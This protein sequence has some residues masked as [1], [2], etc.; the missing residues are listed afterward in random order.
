MSSAIES[1]PMLDEAQGDS[2]R[3]ALV[4][5]VGDEY[6][7]VRLIGRGGMGAVYL[8][9]DRALER[10]VAIKVLPPGSATDAGVLERFRREAKTV[11]SLQHVGIVPLYAFGERRGLV[12]FVMGYVRGES[13]GTRLDR[14]QVLD[15][16][17]AR[18]MLAQVAEALDHAHRQGIVHRDVK[19]DNIL[20]DDSTGRALLTDF[21]IARADTLQSGTSLTQVGAVMGTPHYMSPE[22]ATA[23]PSLDGRSDLYSVG[24]VGYQMLSGTLPFDGASFRELLMQHISVP[25]KPLSAVAPSVPADLADAIMRCLEKDPSK[26]IAD[27]RSLRAA[28]GGSAYDDDTLTYELAELQQLG[29]KVVVTTAI[30]AALALSAL[31]RGGRLFSIQAWVWMLPPLAFLLNGLQVREA[32]KRGYEWGTIRRVVTLPPRWWWLWWPRSWRRAG[33]VYDRLP[34]ALKG[35]RTTTGLLTLLLLAEAPLMAWATDPRRLAI[36]DRIPAAHAFFQAPWLARLDMLVPLVGLV[37]FLL[38]LVVAATLSNLLV[39]RATRGA[40]AG[41]MDRQRLTYKPTDSAFWRDPRIQRIYRQQAADRRPKTPQEF[42]SQILAAAGTL[43]PAASESG[44]AAITGA[45][46]LLD[47]ITAHERELVLLEKTAP[48]EQLE[49]LEAEI[50][51]HESDAGD[52]EAVQLLVDQ[53]DAVLRSRARLLVVSTRR[54][55]AA[56]RLE[57]LWT[58]VRRLASST[59]A[60]AAG[61][62]AAS[63]SEAWRD[64]ERDY[65]VRRGASTTQRSTGAR[66][67]LVLAVGTMLAVQA[68]APAGAAPDAAAL[69]ARGQ[70]DSALAMLA[71]SR[72]SSAPALVLTGQ[73][74]LQRGSQP[75][76]A[77]RYLG[78]RRARA[79]FLAALRRDSTDVQALESLAW[80]ARLLPAF[81]GGSRAETGRL[82]ARLERAHPYRGALMRGHLARADGRTAIADS[83]F[84]HLV[85][86]HPDSAP[87]WFARFDLASRLRRADVAREALGHYRRLMPSDRAALFQ[88]GQLAAELGVDLAA[89]ESA[90]REYLRGPFLPAM[91]PRGQSWW[92]LG[93][94]LEAQGRIADAREAYGNAVAIDRRDA[95]YRGALEALETSTAPRD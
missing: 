61:A 45:R 68:G 48:R 27:G 60:A 67:S 65:P 43:P 11:A 47:A 4:A 69:V 35:A 59:D 34:G 40:D 90:L 84:A 41:Y 81:A 26:R 12:W 78:A 13:L 42:V 53:R 89:G 70:P 44:T 31:L 2:L 57:T 74:Q 72:D 10:L 14:E 30:C 18:T 49:R 3:E 38:V 75:G 88:Q 33:D 36:R 1:E 63:I 24:V 46:R 15:A 21:G 19:P 83:I 5:A 37:V 91:P 29:A 50:V 87:A 17:T 82:T 52:P 80:M 79:A 16:E 25:P 56:A 7:I 8:A 32:R 86:M 85:T 92:R 95:E 71:A 73:A 58:S 6:E 94:V 66:V 64:V 9:R 54:D 62:I 76:V 51:R 39:K 77:S 55:E 20:I 28:V 22:Q 93:Q 23:E